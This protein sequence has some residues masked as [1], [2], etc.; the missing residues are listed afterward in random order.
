MTEERHA[1]SAEFNGIREQKCVLRQ[2]ILAV[3]RPSGTKSNLRRQEFVVDL[4]TQLQPTVV[5]SYLDVVPEPA[6]SAIVAACHKKGISV[7][8]PLLR[9]TQPRWATLTP[10]TQ[11]EPGWAG[12]PTP[13]NAEEFTGFA[14]LVVCSALA[15]TAS[16][17]RLGVGGGWFDQVFQAWPGAVRCGLINE[18][19]LLDSLPVE[20][21]D[22]AL[23]YV[24]TEQRCIATRARRVGGS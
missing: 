11:L 21:H 13:L 18:S 19:E 9:G 22:L 17:W 1:V 6:T 14:D 15:A 3:R 10:G 23:D 20:P 24:V 7:A 12:I 4:I 8:A 5:A 16:G 2:Q